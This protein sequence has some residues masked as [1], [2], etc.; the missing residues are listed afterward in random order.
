MK[1]EGLTDFQ[2]DL[3][4]VEKNAE[5]VFK[6][7]MQTSGNKLTRLVR[8]KGKSLVTKQDGLYHKSFKRGK[9]FI[10]PE[11]D[12]TVRALNTAPHAHLLEYG[13]RKVVNP[14]KEGENYVTNL[15][16]IG[17]KTLHRVIEGKGIGKEVGFVHGVRVMEKGMKE[18]EQ[19]REDVQEISK[20]LDKL[21]SDNKL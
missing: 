4:S 20:A 18:F 1:I 10:D 9:V 3:L 6:K 8:K 11:G 5:K 17:F 21:L 14:P 19:K 13:H 16:G 7:A 15:G 2:N 12:I